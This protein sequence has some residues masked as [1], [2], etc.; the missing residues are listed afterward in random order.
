[1]VKRLFSLSKVM[2]DTSKYLI[3]IV[4]I[5]WR[6]VKSRRSYVSFG[7]H[8]SEIEFTKAKTSKLDIS[9]SRIFI[10]RIKVEDV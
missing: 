7:E 4:N 2:G 5:V 8:C 9:L 10:L 3:Y 6:N 1:M